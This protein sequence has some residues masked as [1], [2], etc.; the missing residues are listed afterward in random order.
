[1][2]LHAAEHLDKAR[3][4]VVHDLAVAQV[5]GGDLRHLLIGQG[6]VPDVDILLH[7]LHMDGLGDNG[8]APLSIPTQDHLGG[9]LAI[10]PAGSVSSGSV[11]I[12]C[13]P[14]AK[15]PQAWGTTP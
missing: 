11:K 14:S 13:L 5:L 2:D 1:M 3:I 9:A 10:L 12:P 15:G 4:A 8:H 7:P 6:E